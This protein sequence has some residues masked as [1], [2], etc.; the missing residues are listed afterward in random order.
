MCVCVFSPAKRIWRNIMEDWRKQARTQTSIPKSVF[1]SLLRKL[2][3]SLQGDLKTGFRACGILPL[4][5]AQV[6]K[7]LPGTGTGDPTEVLNE[8]VT[9]MLRE[10]LLPNPSGGTRK[11]SQGQARSRHRTVGHHPALNIWPATEEKD[12]SAKEAE[13]QR[14]SSVRHK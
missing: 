7:R 11:R 4:D 6:L 5:P 8:S 10:H 3:T 9:S 1:P 12:R 2:W 14:S 13:F